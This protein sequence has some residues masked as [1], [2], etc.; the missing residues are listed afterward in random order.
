[1]DDRADR[2]FSE[3]RLAHV[4]TGWLRTRR[5]DH[6]ASPWGVLRDV[7]DDTGTATDYGFTLLEFRINARTAEGKSSI[8]SKIVADPNTKELGLE[9]FG[10]APIILTKV[11]LTAK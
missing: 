4:S 1:M 7:D 2:L 3:A 10:A 5:D 6:G 11:K 8:T 9:D